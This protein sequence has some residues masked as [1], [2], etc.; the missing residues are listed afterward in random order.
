MDNLSCEREKCVYF[1]FRNS[2]EELH[3]LSGGKIYVISNRNRKS[4]VM[5]LSGLWKFMIDKEV[6]PIDVTKAIA[7]K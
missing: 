7:N 3:K 4:Y 1:K 5:D 6:E 2:L